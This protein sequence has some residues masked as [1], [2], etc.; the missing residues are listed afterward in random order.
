M[1]SMKRWIP[2]LLIVAI[3]LT[4][5]GAVA[6]N[7]RT[8]QASEAAKVTI[9]NEQTGAQVTDGVSHDGVAYVGVALAPLPDDEAAE[10]GLVGSALIARI[11][12]GSPADGLLQ[13]GDI[14][15]AAGAQVVHSPADVVE[16]VRD[17]SPGDILTF[18]VLRDG[19]SMDVEITTG[20]RKPP[21]L[22][23]RG[24]VVPGFTP[25]TAPLFG[26]ENRLIKSEVRM[27]TE[28][29]RRLSNLSVSMQ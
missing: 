8:S 21:S 10:I 25:Y 9:A 5:A 27:E 24:D 28:Q 22:A 26:S 16:I 2:G 12:E 3:V 6:A 17:A 13:E 11:V 4:I 7:A 18:T 14:V 23:F 19:A 1:K 15:T 29:P 20:T